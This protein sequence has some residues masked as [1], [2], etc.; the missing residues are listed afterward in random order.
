VNLVQ[1]HKGKVAMTISNS[2]DHFEINTTHL[3]A[4]A[5]IDTPKIPIAFVDDKRAP[6]SRVKSMTWPELAA[7]LGNVEVGEKDGQSWLPADIEPGPRKGERVKE[8]TLLVMDVEAE[9]IKDQATGIKSVVG[10]EPPETDAMVTEVHLSGWACIMHTSHSHHDPEILPMDQSHPRYRLAFP[11]SRSLEKDE[12]KSLGLHIAG[13]LGIAD[14]IDKGCL[15]PARLYYLPRCPAERLAD[16]R[17]AVIEGS[18]LDVDKLLLE[19][20]REND[21]LKKATNKTQ[22]QKSTS[23]IEAFN[24]AHDVGEILE[25]HGYVV[26][27]RNRWLHPDSTTG[28]PGVRRMP[29]SIPERVFSS[30]GSDPLNDGH[31][32][33]AFDCFRILKHGG[34]IKE[35]VKAAACILN[36]PDTR[37]VADSTWLTEINLPANTDPSRMGQNEVATAIT[38]GLRKILGF[39]ASTRQWFRKEGE[40]WQKTN[41]TNARSLAE[42][43]IQPLRSGFAAGYLTGVLTFLESRL[44]LPKWEARRHLLPM[45]NGVLDINSRLLCRYD[46]YVF[47]WQVPHEYRPEATCP[48]V[49]SWL[50][51]LTNG[52]ENLKDFLLAWMRIVLAGGA[53]LQKYIEIIGPGG[54][55]KSAFIRLC[56][57]LVGENNSVSTDLKTL[58]QSRFESA[59]LYGK[60]LALITDASRYGGEVSTLKAITGG[61]PLRYEQ[62]NVQAGDS[63]VFEGVVMIAANEP[64][65]S[66]DYTSGLARRRI[67]IFFNQT[68][69]EEQKLAMPDFEERIAAE[70]PGLLNLLLC[71]EPQVADRTI[72][73]PGPSIGKA[74]LEAEIETNPLLSWMNE[75][76]IRCTSGAETQIGNNDIEG[77]FRDYTNYCRSQVR[78]PL[79]LTR[80]SRLVIDNAIQRGIKTEKI[81]IKASGARALKNLCLRLQND[82]DCE[83]FSVTGL[84]ER[85]RYETVRTRSSVEFDGFD[86]FLHTSNFST[87]KSTDI[88]PDLGADLFNA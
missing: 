52:D 25:E 44:I 51:T 83:L 4:R 42:D 11:L 56:R 47:N 18:P 9:T 74:K 23:V 30:H 67:P 55:G 85:D 69:S 54:T 13:K 84:P 46:D 21:A 10:P 59:G 16:F 81:R 49:D 58:E 62:K 75:R 17:H 36:L 8:T 12:I 5:H 48:T 60:R 40:I 53:H 68:V 19:V 2:K 86:G 22:G 87:R 71:I 26:K 6:I 88:G 37:H 76:L 32:H 45:A 57:L 33:D 15:E 28:E 20:R 39:E 80:F 3:E 29:D 72:R 14:C 43:A 79:S 64:I 31:A 65:Q 35:A 1:R 24:Q 34:D 7:L 78:E 77:L 70:I 50:I 82:T 63:F 41:L 66:S 61:D 27:G 73:N 38:Q